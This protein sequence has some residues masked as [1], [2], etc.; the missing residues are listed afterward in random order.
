MNTLIVMGRANLIR[1][2]GALTDQRPVN[3]AI[4]PLSVL[5]T[6]KENVELISFEIEAVDPRWSE[7]EI[8]SNTN[9]LPI[10]HEVYGIEASVDLILGLTLNS[11]KYNFYVWTDLEQ[12]HKPAAERPI[13]VEISPFNTDTKYEIIEHE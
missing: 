3:A 8:N 5:E 1:V 13:V 4:R 11:G 2:I 12:S 10:R 7:Y 9:V 6:W